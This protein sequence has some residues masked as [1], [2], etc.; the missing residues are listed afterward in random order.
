MNVES[1]AAMEKLAEALLAD[2]AASRLPRDQ[3][4]SVFGALFGGCLWDRS[5]IR[6]PPLLVLQGTVLCAVNL[7]HRASS[8]P[9]SLLHC[10]EVLTL[11]FCRSLA[12]IRLV[13]TAQSL[14][15]AC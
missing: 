11:H 4:V 7:E 8:C 1:P 5:D 6:Y 3:L 14:A 2:M 13:P 15:N 10:F 9:K 12:R